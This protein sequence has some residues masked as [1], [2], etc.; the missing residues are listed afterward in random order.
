MHRSEKWKILVGHWTI[1]P[2][3]TEW[4]TAPLAKVQL[5]EYENQTLE[6]FVVASRLSDCS[7]A[8]QNLSLFVTAHDC[9][10]V[11]PKSYQR[12]GQPRKTE[13]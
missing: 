1:K 10:T 11:M 5:Y 12:E 7:V 3:Q 2:W 9:D 4:K 8:H 6:A 13:N